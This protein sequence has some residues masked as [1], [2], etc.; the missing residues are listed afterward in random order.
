MPVSTNHTRQ[1]V[2]REISSRIARANGSAGSSGGSHNGNGSPMTAARVSEYFGVNTLGARQMRDKLP[3]E[4]YN[5]LL[6][7]IRLGTKLDSEIA[8]KVA[9]VIRDWAIG[10]GATIAFNTCRICPGASAASKC[11]ISACWDMNEGS[12]R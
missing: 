12:F 4:V 11:L 5:K 1:E 8:P 3:R 9:A 7:A 2:N 6:A 10:R